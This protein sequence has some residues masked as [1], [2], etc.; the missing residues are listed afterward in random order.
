[1]KRNR[2]RLSGQFAASFIC[3]ALLGFQQLPAFA[4]EDP[5]IVETPLTHAVLE[6]DL[7]LIEELLNRGANIEEPD[8]ETDTPLIVAAIK[9]NLPAIEL[10]LK[11]GAKIDHA[12]GNGHT[13]LMAATYVVDK[14]AIALLLQRGA[15]VCLTSKSDETALS[16]AKWNADVNQNSGSL[17]LLGPWLIAHPC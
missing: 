11:H 17:N 9:G 6:G 10:L 16:I 1:M 4:S 14:G 8:S 13:P 3:V 15:D 5:P 2:S 12:A 7:K